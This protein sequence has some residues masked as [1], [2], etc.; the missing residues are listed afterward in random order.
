MFRVRIAERA[1]ARGS[2]A[3]EAGESGTAASAQDDA[4]R[5]AS[6]PS[7]AP[8]SRL[9]RFALGA[10]LVAWM[11][12]RVLAASP[13][14]QARVTAVVVGLTVF[15]MLVHWVVRRYFSWLHPWLGAV[16]AV[17]PVAVVTSLGS[18]PGVA[19]VLY[20]GLSLVLISMRGEPG[21]EVLAVPAMLSRHPTHL[22]CLFFSPLDWVE[23]KILGAS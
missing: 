13:A 12:P 19:A 11:L 1:E 14:N 10:A 21:C 6:I 15:Y 16:V 9:L 22:A 17:V 18:I 2:S 23:Q 3:E 7:A 4:P 20:V 5:V 8:V